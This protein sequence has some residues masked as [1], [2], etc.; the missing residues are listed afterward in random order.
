M[1]RYIF[2]YSAKHQTAS[3][4]TER[5]FHPNKPQIAIPANL[6]SPRNFHTYKPQIPIP[7]NLKPH[8]PPNEPQTHQA[9][10]PYYT[11]PLVF[12]ILPLALP[13]SRYN[14]I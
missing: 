11:P 14:L 9:P 13:V 4:T 6:K 8:P 5:K 1:L 2:T 10:N 7:T 12:S 3:I